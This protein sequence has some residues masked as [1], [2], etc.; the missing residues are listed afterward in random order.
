MSRKL[1]VTLVLILLI[2]P[3]VSWYY[4]QSGLNWRKEAQKL[5]SGNEPFPAGEWLDHAGKTFN[6]EMT[7]DH[8]TIV[9]L[10]SCDRE[11]EISVLLN[12]LYNQFLETKKANFLIL[13]LCESAMIEDSSKLN[14]Y[15]FSCKDSIGLCPK[16]SLS[17]PAG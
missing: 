4:L 12:E 9:T 10:V 2:L 1:V 11:N 6:A 8:V 17:W 16:L 5:M 7:K 14:W 15:V 3:F 13:D